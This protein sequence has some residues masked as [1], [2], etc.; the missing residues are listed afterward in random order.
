M[1]QTTDIYV[2]GD[3]GDHLAFNEVHM[4]LSAAMEG[5]NFRFI[6]QNVPAFDTVSTGFCLAQLAMNVPSTPEGFAKRTKFF[7]NTAPRKDDPKARVK[8]E[9]EALVYF[10]L[11]NGVEG[12][13]VNSG[14]SLSFI[15]EACV[16]IRAINIGK[17]GSQFRS[18]DIFPIAFGKLFN[19]NE[20]IL[21][22]D[23]KS[24]IP[25]YPKDTVVWTDG[26]G[27]LKCSL[28]PDTFNSHMDEHV[29]LY[30]NQYPIF[31]KIAAGIFGVEDGEFCVSTGSSGWPLPNGKE[32]RFVE[33]I[34]RGGNAAETVNFP[35]SGKKIDWSIVK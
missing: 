12:V 3:Y 5:T 14:Y 11:Y 18:R 1:T 28:D 16:E 32:V 25:D 6:D 33:I 10:K 35:H 29:K 26:Y 31:G 4:R 24:D 23:I 34:R 27:N 20:D 2:I 30:I 22:A 17:E 8:C 15:K 21:G 9:G 7:V 13:V 19:D